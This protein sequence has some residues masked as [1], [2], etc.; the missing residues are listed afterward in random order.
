MPVFMDSSLPGPTHRGFIARGD[1]PGPVLPDMGS[2]TG[3]RQGAGRD[4]VPNYAASDTA[5]QH[6]RTKA[7]GACINY[8]NIIINRVLCLMTATAQANGSRGISRGAC[9]R[10]TR[11][12]IWSA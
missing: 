6:A 4:K 10:R 3:K 8:T 5:M 1:A 2:E 7:R 12:W 11:C 9:C